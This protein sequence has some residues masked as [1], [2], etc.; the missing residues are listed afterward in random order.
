[1][2][3]DEVQAKKIG[4]KSTC[5]ALLDIIHEVLCGFRDDFVTVEFWKEKL[6]NFKTFIYMEEK[7]G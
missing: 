5:K 3:C 4:F 2:K 1:M 6:R 7:N